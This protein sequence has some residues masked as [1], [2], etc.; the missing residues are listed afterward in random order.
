MGDKFLNVSAFRQMCGRAGR[1]GLDAKVH[2]LPTPDTALLPRFGR[3][4][5]T[6]IDFNLYLYIAV[7]GEAILMIMAGNKTERT[8][9]DHLLTADLDPLRSCLHIGAGGG[10]EKLLLEMV[11]CGRLCKESEVLR[12]IDCTLM[13]V[14]QDHAAVSH[15]LFPCRDA[16]YC[17]I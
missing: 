8:V 11:S 1:M 9:A 2:T 7:Q 14:Q 3:R 4:K 17:M 12:F 15:Y 6:C 5:C 10:L 13:R 16:P